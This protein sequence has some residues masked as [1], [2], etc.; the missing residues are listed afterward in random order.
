M[1][2]RRRFTK[3]TGHPEMKRASWAERPAPNYTP[4]RISYTWWSCFN[5]IFLGEFLFRFRESYWRTTREYVRELRQV[6]KFSFNETSRTTT[7][8]LKKIQ[9]KFSVLSETANYRIIEIHPYFY[10]T[11]IFFTNFPV[12]LRANYSFNYISILNV[13]LILSPNTIINIRVNRRV[14]E[15]LDLQ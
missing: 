14:L 6:E 11:Y 10:F 7:W 9:T 8:N 1:K 13:I 2:P 3:V 15:T 12:T 4:A 5:E